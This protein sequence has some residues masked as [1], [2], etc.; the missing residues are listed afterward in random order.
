M[1][2]VSKRQVYEILNIQ[3]YWRNGKR[4]RIFSAK[5]ML[6]VARSP[7]MLVNYRVE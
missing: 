3:F 4:N 5:I 7:F 1:R 6:S 2:I